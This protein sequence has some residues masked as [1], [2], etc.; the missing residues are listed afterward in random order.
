MSHTCLSLAVCLSCLSRGFSRESH[1]VKLRD[2]VHEYPSPTSMSPTYS[3]HPNTLHFPSV[4]LMPLLPE[5]RKTTHHQPYRILLPPLSVI[6]PCHANS[7]SYTYLTPKQAIPAQHDTPSQ[8]N[9]VGGEIRESNCPK[10]AFRFQHRHHHR[11][12]HQ[13]N[14]TDAMRSVL[15]TLRRPFA[16]FRNNDW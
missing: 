8:D 3:A 2:R 9:A 16:R 5:M 7:Q 14:A 4:P 15:A 12:R 1:S 6:I 11:H 13:R 10:H